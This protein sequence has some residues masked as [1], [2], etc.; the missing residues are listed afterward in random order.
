MF[1][2][3][4]QKPC[5]VIIVLLLHETLLNDDREQVCNNANRDENIAVK[6]D[7]GVKRI[8]LQDIVVCVPDHVTMHKCK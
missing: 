7:V 5:V 4:L 1:T 2:R 8:D 6:V 3:V